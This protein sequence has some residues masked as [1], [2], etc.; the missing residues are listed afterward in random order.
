MHRDLKTS[1]LLYNNQGQLKICDFGLGRKYLGPNIAYTPTVVTLWYRAPEVLLGQDKY[2]FAIDMWSVG[3][4]MVE[5]INRDLLFKGQSEGEQIDLIF[6]LLGT[7]NDESWNG[8]RDLK[9]SQS[10]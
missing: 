2:S 1:N 10:F 8:W 7:P 9:Y 4:I 5:L 6:R 3:C